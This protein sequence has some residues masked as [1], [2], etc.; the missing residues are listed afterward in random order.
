MVLDTTAGASLTEVEDI[1]A[2]A[3]LSFGPPPLAGTSGEASAN[4][5]T[6]ASE[7]Q[8]VEPGEDEGYE[9]AGTGD[10]DCKSTR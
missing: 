1:G 6:P 10:E 5:A 7:S 4:I 8:A 9:T 2:G 3:P